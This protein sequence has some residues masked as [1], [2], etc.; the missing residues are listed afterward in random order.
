MGDN[1]DIFANKNDYEVILNALNCTS[2]I[3]KKTID[4]L[5]DVQQKKIINSL[6]NLTLDQF[7]EALINS[8]SIIGSTTFRQSLINKYI[9]SFPLS[10]REDIKKNIIDKSLITSLPAY[11]IPQRGGSNDGCVNLRKTI[12]KYRTRNSPPYPA[13]K[14]KS[15]KKKGNDGKMYLSE[16]DKNGVYKWVPINKN[17][18]VKSKVTAKDLRHLAKKYLVTVSGSKSE[19]AKR[20][21]RLRGE[22]MINATDKAMLEP[23]L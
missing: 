10:K 4:E 13:N 23:F 19:L 17:K 9:Y 2:S 3:S 5:S 7:N 15:T 8:Q 20:I 1:C 14:C 22:K 16:S 12:S 21:M 18:T 11:L 6:K